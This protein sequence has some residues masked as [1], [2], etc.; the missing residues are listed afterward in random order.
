MSGI[1][2]G[3]SFVQKGKG[4]SVVSARFAQAIAN[5]LNEGGDKVRTQVQRALWK[6]TGA[7]KYA[8]ITSR[9]RTARAFGSGAPKSGIGPVGAGSLSYSIIVAG[10]PV[11]KLNEF[12]VRNDGHGVEANVWGVEHDFKRSFMLH[13]GYKARLGAE[14]FPIRTLF[15]PNLAKELTKG[16][17]P[18]VFLF[19][20]R[21]FVGPAILKHMVKAFG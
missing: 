5:G 6:Q 11:M 14:R 13:G 4:F 16:A 15:G 10:K 20:A 9:V 2:L 7:T 19:S 3:M 21:E 17:T 12:K 18:G 1:A 8:S